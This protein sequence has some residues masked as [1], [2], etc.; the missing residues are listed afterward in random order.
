MIFSNSK[1][2]LF[3]YLLYIPSSFPTLLPSLSLIPTSTL[4]SS[5]ILFSSISAQKTE[6]SMAYRVVVKLSIFHYI[7][8]EKGDSVGGVG[9]QKPV[10]ESE[11]V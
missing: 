2:V 11:T 10:K 6:A 9:F 7:K 8:A 1:L 4:L 3:I 5:T